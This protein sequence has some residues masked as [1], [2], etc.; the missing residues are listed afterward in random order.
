MA[1]SATRNPRFL[2]ESGRWL[3]DKGFMV[4]LESLDCD[5]LKFIR[6]ALFP[7]YYLWRVVN[8]EDSLLTPVR[9]VVDPTMSE[10]NLTLAKGENRIG[11]LV[12][13]I[14]RSQVNPNAWSSVVTNLYNQLHLER[15]ARP[16][17]LFL[18]SDDPDLSCDSTPYVMTGAW[19]GVV[20]TGN[21]AGYALEL[22]VQSTAEEFPDA[23]EPLTRHQYVDCR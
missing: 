23:V 2:R 7:H 9:L 5:T 15:A 16:Y 1:I 4:P 6:E 20:P 11:S 18:Y 8:K 19:C 3:V 12:N 22:L 21:Q 14:L 17:S 13:I 10:L